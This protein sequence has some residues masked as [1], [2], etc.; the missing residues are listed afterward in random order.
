MTARKGPVARPLTIRL[1][2]AHRQ[3]HD[4]HDYGTEHDGEYLPLVHGGW[5]M[6]AGYVGEVLLLPFYFVIRFLVGTPISLVV[7]GMRQWLLER[8]SSF[9]I[10]LSYRREISAD[11]PRTMWLLIELACFLR[12]LALV[13]LVLLGIAS[14]WRF[15]Q[16]YALACF[17]LGLNQFRTLAAH[18]YANAGEQMTHHD[19]FLDSTNVTGNW[20][21][22][23]VCPL[24]LRYHAL[25]HLLPGIPYHNLATAHRELTEKLPADSVYHQS[26][27][28]SCWSVIGEV[29]KAIRSQET[30][31]VAVGHDTGQAA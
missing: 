3:H 28:K 22:P 30:A 9:V 18:R 29:L 16:L 14:P 15:V 17:A 13:G 5:R 24:G 1:T 4:S 20:L 11:A 21:T 8:H 7:P 27:Y 19:Q 2:E 23:L 26:T 12:I 31:P 10:N 6:F 25:H